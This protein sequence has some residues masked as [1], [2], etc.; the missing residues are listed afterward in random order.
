[1]RRK[2]IKR[3]EIALGR[4]T[5]EARSKAGKDK[6]QE[7]FPR[8]ILKKEVEL[9]AEEKKKPIMFVQETET[10]K[11][12]QEV[13]M[14][15]LAIGE[16]AQKHT[17]IEGPV[18][19]DADKVVVGAGVRRRPTFTTM[20]SKKK[21]AS[22]ARRKIPITSRQC[23]CEEKELKVTTSSKVSLA[24]HLESHLGK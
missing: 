16:P 7:N 15:R 5:D 3:K 1:M 4:C 11:N 17:R 2:E 12:E 18:R 24:H 20:E 23:R 21:K 6:T 19:E 13:L 9:E 8:T 14:K 10:E 22:E